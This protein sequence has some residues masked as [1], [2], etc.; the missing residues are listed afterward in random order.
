MKE[1]LELVEEMNQGRKK[2]KNLIEKAKRS[3]ECEKELQK[4][5]EELTTFQ[6]EH[7]TQIHFC[8]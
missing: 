3:N 7:S 1:I 5:R 6:M 8:K 4:C 2:E